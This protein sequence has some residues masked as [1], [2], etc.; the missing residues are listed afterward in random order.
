MNF[1][2]NPLIGQY[3]QILLSGSRL[4]SKTDQTTES[5]VGSVDA[6]AS[7][8]EDGQT[9]LLSDPTPFNSETEINRELTKTPASQTSSGDLLAED[10]PPNDPVLCD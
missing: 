8:A 1:S 9:D 3:D 2:V 5:H 4:S 10:N 6:V 7:K